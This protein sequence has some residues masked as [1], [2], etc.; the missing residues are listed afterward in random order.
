MTSIEIKSKVLDKYPNAVCRKFVA[1]GPHTY[2]T[3]QFTIIANGT[4]L[5]ATSFEENLAWQYAY[6]RIYNRSII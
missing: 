4:E 3:P 5:G 6:Q 2:S 1:T